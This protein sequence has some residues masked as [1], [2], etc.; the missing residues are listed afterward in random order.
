MWPFN[1]KKKE[2]KQEEKAEAKVGVK[3]VYFDTEDLKK[4]QEI[5]RQLSIEKNRD[6]KIDELLK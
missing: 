2:E 6:D 1:R 5:G 3:L 4:L